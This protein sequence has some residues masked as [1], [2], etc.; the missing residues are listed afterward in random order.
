VASSLVRRLA[1]AS[2]SDGGRSANA[3]VATYSRLGVVL[4]PLTLVGALVASRLSA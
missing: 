4:A 2:A 1:S 3:S